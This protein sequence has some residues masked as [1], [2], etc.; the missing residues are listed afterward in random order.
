MERQKTQFGGNFRLRGYSDAYWAKDR[1]ERKSTYGYAF[2]LGG[3][4]ISWCSKKQSCIALY[5][6]ESEYVA[7]SAA[8]QEAVWLR[9]FMQRLNC[10][11]KSYEAVLVH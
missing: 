2:I 10:T 8:V 4:A 11:A 6:M 1:D 7:C 3:G 9:R 5:T